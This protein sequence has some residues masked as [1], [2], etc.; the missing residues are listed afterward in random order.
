[1]ANWKLML[2]RKKKGLRAGHTE[3][4]SVD[5]T[6]GSPIVEVC[7]NPNRVRYGARIDAAQGWRSSFMSL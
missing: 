1:M 4:G 7:R 5:P 6:D 2:S 3:N